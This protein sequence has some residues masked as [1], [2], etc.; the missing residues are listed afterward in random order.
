LAAVYGP[1]EG[2]LPAFDVAAG[3]QSGEAIKK[4]MALLQQG[5]DTGHHHLI[6]EAIVELK[7]LRSADP[8]EEQTL[9]W[10][11]IALRYHAE[12]YVLFYLVLGQ[13]ELLASRARQGSDPDLV[14]VTE[15]IRE[16]LAIR[17]DALEA[18]TRAWLKKNE[19]S[20][21]EEYLDERIQGLRRVASRVP[22]IR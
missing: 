15:Q 6:E 5:H 14:A 12:M 13:E 16:G 9:R 22:A 3:R 11:E 4:G 8:F 7:E 19:W 17:L 21:I 18:D 2:W 20:N 10:W 1:W